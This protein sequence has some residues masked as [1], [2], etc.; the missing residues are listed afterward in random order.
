M[1][2]YK[3]AEVKTLIKQIDEGKYSCFE[4][5]SLKI[6]KSLLFTQLL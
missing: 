3:L 5:I 6:I 1:L 4:G 2:I